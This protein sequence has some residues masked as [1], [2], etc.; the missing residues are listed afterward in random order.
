MEEKKLTRGQQEVREKVISLG[1]C[2]GCG[3][4]INLCPYFRSH[5][6]KTSILFP[7]TVENGRC[8]AFCPK[9]EV[10]LD[11]LSLSIFDQP[12]DGNALGRYRS[13]FT[14]KAGEKIK[15]FEAQAG[16]TV[17]SLV[18]YALTK[19]YISGAVLTDRRGLEP[20]PRYVTN[21]EDVFSCSQSKYTA[22]P[23]LAVVNEVVEKG[24]VNIGVVGTPCQIL[25]LA[26]MK[27]REKPYPISLSIG[28]FCT[29]AI[30]FR[31]F[32]PFIS[33][34]I[35]ASHIRKV[36]IPPPPAEI[37]QIFTSQ[38]EKIEIPLSEIRPLVPKGCAYCMDM[39][40]EFSDISVGVLEGRPDMNTLIVRTERGQKLVD[41]AI[42]E[43]YLIVSDMPKENLEH[44]LWAAGNKKQRAL[45]R[46]SDEN[47]INCESLSYLRLK[48]ELLNQLT[49]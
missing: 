24:E 34:W 4:C 20:I 49:Q 25:A 10:D 15:S 8:F 48:G 40:S 13:I 14:A 47:L 42:K 45:K 2:T 21:A 11:N 22:A 38:G 37:L 27:T 19:G 17:S 44:L 18:Y 3:A 35:Q 39:T 23:T 16:G 12:Y 41:E 5:R 43:G 7:C 9:I 28:L 32:E 6:G 36:D 1:L 29:W 26:Q 33:R 46:A 30:D 31:L